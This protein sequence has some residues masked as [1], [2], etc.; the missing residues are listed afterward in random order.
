MNQTKVQNSGNGYTVATVGN[1]NGFTGKLFLREAL[2]LTSMEVSFGTLGVGEAVPFFHKHKQNE[3]VY[4]VLSGKGIFTLDG[5]EYEVGEGSVVSVAPDV[6]RCT[7]N[8][9]DSP[10]TYLCIQAKASSLEQAVA[11][12]AIIKQ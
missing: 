5:R 3:E 6:D 12:D 11:D 8:V 7:K 2:G 1:I 4:I 10:M 9:G